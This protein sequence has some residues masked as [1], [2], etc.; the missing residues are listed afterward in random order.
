M[1]RFTTITI[2]YQFNTPAFIAGAYQEKPELRAPSFKGML[3]WWYRAI[4]PR[5]ILQKNNSES[6]EDKIWGGTEANAGQSHVWIRLS[7]NHIDTFWQWDKNQFDRFTQGRGRFSKN[8]I[9]YLG[10]TFGLRGNKERKAI[11]PDQ[12]FKLSFTIVRENQ[13]DYED[14][15]AIAASIWMF[16]MLGSC[17]TRS[18]RGFGSFQ[19]VEM[20]ITGRNQEEWIGIFNSFNPFTSINNPESFSVAISVALNAIRKNLGEFDNCSHPH[21]G[22]SFKVKF[23]SSYTDWQSAL[24]AAGMAMQDFRQRREPDCS[25]VKNFLTSPEH[26]NPAPERV[27]FGLPLEFRFAQIRNTTRFYPQRL[28]LKKDKLE[29]FASPLFIKIIRFSNQYYPCFFLMDGAKPGVE[30]PVRSTINYRD[31]FWEKTEV[32]LVKKFFDSL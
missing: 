21:C 28:T 14:K 3:R 1:S 10:Y 25:R 8:G 16:S 22:T 19:P 17:G 6:P 23:L 20:T 12:N 7:N 32:N 24:N 2:Q 18:R 26:G 5:I 31:Y 4:D 30:L 29:R 11:A 27:T 9:R 13:L 15:F